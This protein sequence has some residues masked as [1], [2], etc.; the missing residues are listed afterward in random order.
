MGSSDWV[1]AADALDRGLDLW[2]G[3]A[4]EDIEDS[5]VIRGVRVRLDEQRL[6]ALETRAE[7]LLAAGTR[8]RL[9]RNWNPWSRRI[10]SARACGRS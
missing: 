7:A 4:F 3:S 5:A 10:R 8:R 1:A 9:R 6:V 2:R